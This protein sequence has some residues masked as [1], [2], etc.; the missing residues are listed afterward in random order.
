MFCREDGGLLN[1]QRLTEAFGGHVKAAGLPKVP[2]HDLRH[3]WA[4]LALTGGVPVHV[5]SARLGHS[6]PSI[7]LTC[8][9]TCCRLR[10]EGGG[11]GR[12]RGRGRKARGGVSGP[13]VSSP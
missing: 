4:T 1:P 7:T 12:T 11:A 5:V 6:S 10:R 2:V 13:G 9:R 3:T 8:T